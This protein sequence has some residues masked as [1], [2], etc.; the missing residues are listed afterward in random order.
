M[1]LLVE[2]RLINSQ[3]ETEVKNLISF[4]ESKYNVNDYIYPSALHRELKIDL[5]Q[6]YYILEQAVQLELLEE[7]LQ[8]YCYHCQ[9]YAGKQYKYIVDIPDI[10]YCSSCDCEINNPIQYTAV[11]YK[12]KNNG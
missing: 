10:E 5:K 12:V 9:H 11:V 2:K 6:I 3:N 4:I 8:L 1:P 7:Y